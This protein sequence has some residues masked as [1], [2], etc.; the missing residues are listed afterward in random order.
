MDVVNPPQGPKALFARLET[1]GLTCL[2][3]RDGEFY[4]SREHGIRPLMTWLREDPVF[5]R[6]GMAA[7]RVIGK[8]AAMLFVYGGIR[9]VYAGVIS[10]L[11]LA[12]FE[13]AGIA[14]EYGRLVPHIINRDHTGYC[15]METLV[16]DLD[17]PAE[18]YARL[19]EKVH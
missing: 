15:P 13:K 10:E 18:A 9:A 12:V 1:E 7:D 16:A 6:G 3:S 8:A 2:V 4:C 11:A 19:D 14:V 17:D 5:C